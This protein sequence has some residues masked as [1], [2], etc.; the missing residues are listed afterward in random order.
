MRGKVGKKKRHGKQ[1]PLR[2]MK[3]CSGAM[4]LRASGEKAK[5]RRGV[6]LERMGEAFCHPFPADPRGGATG[7]K[8]RAGQPLS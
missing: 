2:S 1:G 5:G 3:L 7:A 6:P 4:G 8:H